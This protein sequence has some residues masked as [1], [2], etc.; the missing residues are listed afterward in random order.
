MATPSRHHHHKSHLSPLGVDRFRTP[1]ID[2]L[3]ADRTITNVIL[4]VRNMTTAMKI[5]VVG[6]EEGLRT[7]KGISS[8]EG[9]S[10][11]KCVDSGSRTSESCDESDRVLKSGGDKE[12]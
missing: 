8:L 6:N 3:G 11:R 7:L 9:D 1:R 10:N 4:I 2:R 5:E 12:V